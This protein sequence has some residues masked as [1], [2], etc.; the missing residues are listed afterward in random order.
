MKTFLGFFFVFLSA[1]FL[2]LGIAG[3]GQFRDSLIN[4][5]IYKDS[6]KGQIIV[7]DSSK[8]EFKKNFTENEYRIISTNNQNELSLDATKYELED[9]FKD[10]QSRSTSDNDINIEPPADCKYV[11]FVLQTKPEATFAEELEYLYC[12]TTIDPKTNVI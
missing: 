2:V 4:N 8:F 6:D 3:V 10:W 5:Y 11:N 12:S 9:F 1:M 7:I